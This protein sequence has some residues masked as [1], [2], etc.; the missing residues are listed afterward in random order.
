[1]LHD[2]LQQAKEVLFG[3]AWSSAEQERWR[4]LNLGFHDGILA[5]A[6]NPYLTQAVVNARSL[7]PIYDVG[8]HE[9]GKDNIWPLLD[10]SFGQQAFS[11]HVRILEAIEAGQGTRAENLM[12]EHIFSNREKTR[13]VI[14]TMLAA[15][16]PPR[17][18]RR[19]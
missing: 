6:D 4:L 1:L 19:Q 3:Q 16:P 10:Q 17:R 11:D 14:E 18:R 12:K 5:Q 15:E 2:N 9:V 7:P 8:E 13:R